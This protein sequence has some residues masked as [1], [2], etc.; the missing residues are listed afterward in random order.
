MSSM[1]IKAVEGMASGR[2]VHGSILRV[3]MLRSPMEDHGEVHKTALANFMISFQ[4]C[5]TL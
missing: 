3:A 1:H 5:V 4:Q 2:E